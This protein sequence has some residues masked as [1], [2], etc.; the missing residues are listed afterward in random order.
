MKIQPIPDV[1]ILQNGN[2]RLC[3]TDAKSWVRSEC[4]TPERW[5]TEGV[6][7]ELRVDQKTLDAMF[8]GGLRVLRQKK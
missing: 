7:T 6:P 8:Q 5:K 1:V 3:T 2:V 4:Y